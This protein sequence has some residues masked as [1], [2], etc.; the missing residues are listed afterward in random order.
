[1]RNIPQTLVHRS[2]LQILRRKYTGTATCIY[3]VIETNLP[4][5]TVFARPS[6]GDCTSRI[7]DL[8]VRYEILGFVW[9]EFNLVNFSTV[10]GMCT[11]LFG[12]FEDQV[13]CLGTNDIPSVSTRSK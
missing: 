13:V 2:I 8:E 3:N 4:G 12:V 7:R 6:S 11:A 10:V 9:L 1:M 5:A